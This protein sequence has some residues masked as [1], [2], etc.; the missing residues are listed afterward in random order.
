MKKLSLFLTT[1][2][3]AGNGFCGESIDTD[4]EGPSGFNTLV[5]QQQEAD[6][7]TRSSR[8]YLP[9]NLPHIGVAK[10]I[11]ERLMATSERDA[12]EL[13]LS[14][15][16]ADKLTLAAQEVKATDFLKRV[17]KSGLDR[18][19]CKTSLLHLMNLSDDH[20]NAQKSL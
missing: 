5:N 19:Y 20:L 3:V 8:V 12:V 6:E 9:A 13:A 2:F 11:Q 1:A 15:K 14:Y 17:K 4:G 16:E 7:V 18:I 10:L